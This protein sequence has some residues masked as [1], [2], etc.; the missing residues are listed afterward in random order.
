MFANL[1]FHWQTALMRS[2]ESSV[3]VFELELLENDEDEDDSCLYADAQQLVSLL[4]PHP[5]PLTVEILWFQAV[6]NQCFS[7]KL[8][9]LR[10]R[11]IKSLGA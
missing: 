3:K 9:V 10:P 2:C 11:L 4:S 5:S 7:N 1:A 8:L 6:V